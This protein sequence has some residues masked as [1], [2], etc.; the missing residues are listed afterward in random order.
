MLLNGW[1]AKAVLADKGYDT[2]AILA[3]IEA[4]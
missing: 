1:Q 3:Q 2:N 4:T